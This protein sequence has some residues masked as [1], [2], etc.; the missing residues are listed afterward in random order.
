MKKKRLIIGAIAILLLLII[1]IPTGVLKDG[2]TRTYTALTY[3]LVRW[4]HLH[5]GGTYKANSAS[6]KS[7][8]QRSTRSSNACFMAGT[9]CQ[10]L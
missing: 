2:G 10:V 7:E 1:P 9:D 3:K 4:N 5:D 8:S 6:G